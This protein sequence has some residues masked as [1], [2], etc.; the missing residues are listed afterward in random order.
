LGH[1]RGEYYWQHRA[2]NEDHYT[3]QEI[4][5]YVPWLI[6]IPVINH[7]DKKEKKNQI[8]YKSLDDSPELRIIQIKKIFKHSF[9]ILGLKIFTLIQLTSNKQQAT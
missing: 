4:A 1:G 5:E 2:N 6:R 9:D 8:Y 7:S 3:H